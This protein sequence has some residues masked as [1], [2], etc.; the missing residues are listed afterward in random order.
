MG[1]IIIAGLD[2]RA[3]KVAKTKDETQSPK[4]LTATWEWNLLSGGMKYEGVL[5]RRKIEKA[6][7][8][9][10]SFAHQRFGV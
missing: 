9:Y 1:V 8:L 3:R 4:L 7:V 2:L 5:L 10:I 6:N